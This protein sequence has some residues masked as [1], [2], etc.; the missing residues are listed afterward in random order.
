[1]QKRFNIFLAVNILLFF[2]Q[3]YAQ[4]QYKQKDLIGVWRIA[5]DDEVARDSAKV[6]QKEPGA[7]VKKLLKD[8]FKETLHDNYIEFK[9]NGQATTSFF[10]KVDKLV[11]WKIK[12]NK[13]VLNK[14]G[15]DNEITII[16]LTAKK[17]RLGTDTDKVITMIRV[18]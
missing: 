7:K 3:G 17:L 13:L 12:Q 9:P 8:Y 11:T 10:G 2:V 15:K 14:K 1:M 4:A 6:Q 18:K 16:E 5:L